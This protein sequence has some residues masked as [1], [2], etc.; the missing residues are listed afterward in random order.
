MSGL[1]GKISYISHDQNKMATEGNSCL[2]VTLKKSLTSFPIG[3]IVDAQIC[4]NSQ[5]CFIQLK[6]GEILLWNTSTNSS[7]TLLD[8]VS[9]S[10]DLFTAGIS[11]PV[12]R[13][14]GSNDHGHFIGLY[15]ISMGA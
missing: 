13:N 8:G 5:L 9:R 2:S 15:K 7:C 3:D 10:V 12:V 4:R 11:G 1:S 6:D 14:H